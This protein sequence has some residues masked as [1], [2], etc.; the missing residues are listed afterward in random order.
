MAVIIII[1]III[2]IIMADLG[3]S[4]DPTLAASEAE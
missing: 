2:I 4:G 1:I 3:G